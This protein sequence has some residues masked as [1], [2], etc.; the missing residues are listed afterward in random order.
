VG[1]RNRIV[2]KKKEKRC[3]EETGGEG[4]ECE[5]CLEVNMN[6][7]VQECKCEGRPPK[8]KIRQRTEEGIDNETMARVKL[9]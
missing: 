2:G 7:G 9:T 6:D 8:A 5:P 4:S 1:R 3:R